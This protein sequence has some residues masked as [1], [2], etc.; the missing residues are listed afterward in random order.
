MKYT[1]LFYLCFILV[2]LSCK[3]KGCTDINATNY[4]E[5]ATKDD[6]SCYFEGGVVFW[7]DVTTQSIMNLYGITSLTYIIGDANTGTFQI[8]TSWSMPPPCGVEAS[9]GRT[10]EFTS[11]EPQVF[12]YLIYDQNGIERWTGSTIIT[13]GGCTSV[14]LEW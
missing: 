2:I 7:Y 3:K 10:F 11:N 4:S 1:A 13:T 14:Q 9:I 5:E 6:G 12:D 8:D